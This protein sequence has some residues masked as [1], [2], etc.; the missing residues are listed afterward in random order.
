MQARKVIYGRALVTTEHLQMNL[1]A[2]N[3]RPCI[4]NARHLFSTSLRYRKQKPK[5][6]LAK[7]WPVSLLTNIMF[8]QDYKHGFKVSVLF[9]SLTSLMSWTNRSMMERHLDERS[10]TRARLGA[11]SGT[12]LSFHESEFQAE[13][14]ESVPSRETTTFCVSSVQSEIPGTLVTARVQWA[15]ETIER[16]SP[17]QKMNSFRHMSEDERSKR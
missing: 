12:W 1:M 4:F 16:S 10:A 13:M 5:Q 9:S 7:W 6:F 2:R 8:P 17:L 11:V 15:R 14:T 3:P